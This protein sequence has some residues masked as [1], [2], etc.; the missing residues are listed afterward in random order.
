MRGLYSD[1]PETGLKARR[2]GE[3][4]SGILDRYRDPSHLAL[5]QR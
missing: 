3:R 5:P 1:W 2:Q 4:D